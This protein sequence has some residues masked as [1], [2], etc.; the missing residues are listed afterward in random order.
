MNATRPGGFCIAGNFQSRQRVA[1]VQGRFQY[2]REGR[3]PDGIE[4]KMQIVGAVNFI[5]ARVPGIQI[6]ASEI[7]HP[8]QGSQVLDYR[9][10]R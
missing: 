10:I 3:V 7:H 5:A 1:H 9:E 4:I 8:E 2:P 6:D